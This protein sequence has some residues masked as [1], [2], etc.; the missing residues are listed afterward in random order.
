MTY[1]VLSLFPNPVAEQSLRARL[2]LINKD[3]LFAS[4]DADPE[5]IGAG[6]VYIDSK[7][8]KVVLRE[9]KPVCFIKP[10]KVVFR[11]P[12]RAMSTPEFV[13]EVKHNKDSSRVV[14]EALNTGV[15]CGAAVLGWSVFITSVGAAPI[16]GG[17]SLTVTFISYSAAVASS[18]QCLVGVGRTGLAVGNSER[19]DWLDEEEWYQTASGYLDAVSLGGVAASGMATARAVLLLK[20][21]GIGIREALKG[22]GR[23]KRRR[24]TQEIQRAKHPHWSNKMMKLAQ[25]RGDFPTRY[26]AKEISAGVAR[27]ARDAFGA[28]LS[29]GGSATSGHVGKLVVGVYEEFN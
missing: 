6:V 22:L 27:Q 20:A 23:A 28:F 7:G 24:L 3:K 26:T 10:I 18:V 8:T 4:I 11:E 19:L 14:M 17:A 5:L 13:S 2:N 15:A 25:R 29:F 9:F 16:S 1:S 12:P 21:Q